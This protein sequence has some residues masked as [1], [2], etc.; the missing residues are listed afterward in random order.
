MR[1]AK[2]IGLAMVISG[3]VLTA[4]GSGA[5]DASEAGRAV[6]IETAD[7][8]NGFLGV[9]YPQGE[10]VQLSSGD[11]D[12]GGFCF[13]GACSQ[14]RYNDRTVLLLTDNAGL[15]I[16]NVDTSVDNG[17]ITGGSGVRDE[18]TPNGLRAIVG[19]FR[20]PASS[21][22]GFFSIGDQG[23]RTG[24]VTATIDAQENGGSMRVELER[25][26]QIECIPD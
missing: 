10:P 24:T 8:Q 22:G 4:M 7:D 12:G 5:F 9:E 1:T 11:A 3:A 2:L 20:C 15:S 16:E 26:V 17:A 23:A 18:P 14:Y 6:A 13:F 19:D 25:Q 21:T